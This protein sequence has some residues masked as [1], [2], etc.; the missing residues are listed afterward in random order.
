MTIQTANTWLLDEFSKF[1][2]RDTLGVI[3]DSINKDNFIE[4]LSNFVTTNKTYAEDEIRKNN[5]AEADRLINELNSLN[6]EIL[7]ST[8]IT[9]YDQADPIPDIKLEPNPEG[10]L[11]TSW[12]NSEM[13]ILFQHAMTIFNGGLDPLSQTY[14]IEKEFV[15]KS[16]TEMRSSLDKIENIINGLV[17]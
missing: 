12:L 16:M 5:P 4:Q 13:N 14:N 7:K 8:Y 6:Y 3:I 9:L 1:Y 15:M 17:K 10:T 11:Y 2:L